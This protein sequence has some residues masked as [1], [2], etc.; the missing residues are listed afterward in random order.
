MSLKETFDDFVED[1]VYED[2]LRPVSPLLAFGI[3]LLPIFF[4]WLL[5]RPG[6][7]VRAR[8]IGFGWFGIGVILAN[9]FL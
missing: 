6:Y 3:F 8:T 5:L 2:A 9:F 1:L 7:S 4:V